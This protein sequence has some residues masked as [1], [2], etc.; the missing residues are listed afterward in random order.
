ML[1]DYK[2]PIHL[3]HIPRLPLTAS[4]TSACPLRPPPPRICCTHRVCHLHPL[5]VHHVHRAYLIH[6]VRHADCVPRIH[7][8]HRV[9]PVPNAHRTH[10][11]R[12]VNRAIFCKQ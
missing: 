12:Q 3:S 10:N 9:R 6:H 5:R 2:Q 7:H 1:C 11:I 8:A 4:A